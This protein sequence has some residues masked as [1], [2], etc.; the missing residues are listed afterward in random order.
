ML[1]EEQR[2]IFPHSPQLWHRDAAMET[3]KSHLILKARTHCRGNGPR[4]GPGIS[5]L[6]ENLDKLSSV[7]L[8]GR[9]VGGWV[10]GGRGNSQG[11]ER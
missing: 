6:L 7:Q 1:G 10:G 5:G 9:W 8:R 3:I 11:Q 2:S 4:R